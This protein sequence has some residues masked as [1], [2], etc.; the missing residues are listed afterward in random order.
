M[1]LRV[2]NDNENMLS[3]YQRGGGALK[4]QVLENASTEKSSTE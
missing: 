2:K 1:E 3:L 4:L